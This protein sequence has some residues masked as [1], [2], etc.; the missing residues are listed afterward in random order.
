MIFEYDELKE[1]VGEDFERFDKMGFDENQI[2]PAVLNEYEHG[3]DF[4]VVENVCIHVFLILLYTE[5]SLNPSLIIHKLN[6]FMNEEAGNKIM[7][8]LGTEYSKFIT[9]LNMARENKSAFQLDDLGKGRK[10]VR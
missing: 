5:K 7:A 10:N 2:F 3:K 1:Y 4:G 9:D 6:Q 8:E